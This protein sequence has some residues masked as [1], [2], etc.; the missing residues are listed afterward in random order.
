MVNIFSKDF[1]NDYGEDI[2]FVRILGMIMVMICVYKNVVMFLI[3]KG[4]KT[5]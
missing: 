4:Y 2:C 3:H 5:I 1:K